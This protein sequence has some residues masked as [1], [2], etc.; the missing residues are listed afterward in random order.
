MR[1]LLSALVL[2]VAAVCAGLALS[3]CAAGAAG[4]TSGAQI[5]V[6]V[7]AGNRVLVDGLQLQPSAAREAVVAFARANP[8]AVVQLCA[9]PASD[10]AIREA[11]MEETRGAV[12]SASELLASGAGGERRAPDAVSPP[13]IDESSCR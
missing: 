7:T 1:A 5:A 6:F 3:G 13:R 4:T 10:P 2:P 12:R 11:L 9:S 8:G